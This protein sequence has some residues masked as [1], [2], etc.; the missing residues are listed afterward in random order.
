MNAPAGNQR[1][2][3]GNDTYRPPTETISTRDYEVAPIEGDAEAK[4]FVERHHYSG[5]YPAARFRYGLFHGGVRLVGVAVFSVGMNPRTITNA[6]PT[7]DASAGVVLGR[8]VLLDSVPGNGETW[9]LG[10]CFAALKK[11]DLCGVV[12]FSDPMPR[13]ALS[14]EVAFKGHLG[15]IYQAH[16]AWYVGR[17]TSR[18]LRLLPD[19]R[20]FSARAMSK[21]R[22]ADTGWRYAARQLVE[23]G[24]DE[25]GC[26]AWGGSEGDP[27]ELRQWLAGVQ[28][29]EVLRKARHP[30]NHKYAWAFD[31]RELRSNP[32]SYP[33]ALDS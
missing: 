8:F 33:K 26:L 28:E 2:R 24:A 16:N 32:T 21:I 11:H 7:E 30:G 25:P 3:D 1:W 10:Q 31:S 5:T 23:A 22:S 12:S 27:E 15:T 4:R 13:W 20:T 6:L 14:G 19:G 9:F 17:S 18:T 29:S